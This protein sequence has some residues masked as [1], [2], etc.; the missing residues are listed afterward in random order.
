MESPIRL[1][2]DGS[3]MPSVCTAKDASQIFLEGE[4][5]YNRMVGA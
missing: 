5:L 1:E 4:L 2:Y 3:R